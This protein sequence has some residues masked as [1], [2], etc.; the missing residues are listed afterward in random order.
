MRTF[1]IHFEGQV[2]GVGF[3]PHAFQLAS[4]MDLTG[5]ISNG[6]DGVTIIVNG[7]KRD[8]YSFY[9]D[10]LFAPP[11]NAIITRS[12]IEEITD[13]HFESF[14][15]VESTAEAKPTLMVTPDLAMC[16]SCRSEL[17]DPTNRR[18]H[19][20]FTTCLN[21][22][23]R[24]SIMEHLPYDRENTAM[25]DFYLCSPCDNEYH[26]PLDR[27]HHSQTNSCPDCAIQLSL[28]DA[29]GKSLQFTQETIIKDAV[30]L[31]RRGKIIA[32]KGIGGFLLMCDAGSSA[33]VRMLRERKHRPTKPFALLYPSLAMAKRDLLVGDV[34]EKALTSKESP[35]VLLP[36]NARFNSKMPLEQIAPGLNKI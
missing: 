7:T 25:K 31:L 1:Q 26:N 5:S 33:T 15:I 8:C 18:H 29:E 35:I 9:H 13:Q 23:P 24:Y 20:A 3:R 21:C 17:H 2:Q 6:T 22:G 14:S 27:R 10:L 30:D 4:K 36:V 16:E 28:L 12:S 11:S 19:Y 34:E 32:V